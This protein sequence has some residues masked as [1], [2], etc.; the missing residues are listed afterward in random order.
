MSHTK[1]F[2]EGKILS[3]LIRFALPVLFAMFLQTMY[4]AVDMLVVGQ[5]SDA[6]AVSAVS[7]GSWVMHSV[8]MGITALSMGTTVLLGMRIGEGR[9][10][11]AGRVVGGSIAFF[12]SIA[13]AMTVIMFALAPTFANML[14]APAEAFGETVSYIRICALGGI[15]IVAYNLIGSIF[16]G[17][18]NSK[19]PLYSVIIACVLNIIGDL[20]FVGP[21]KMSA[22]GAALATVISQGTSVVISFFLIKKMG[23]PFDFSVK[24]IGFHKDIIKEVTGIGL[25]VAFQDVLV[26]ISFL[27]ITAIVNSLGVVISAGVGIAEKLCGFIM[28]VPSAFGQS[29]S[30]FVAQNIGAKRPDRARK[31]L[32]YAVSV[33]FIVGVLMFYISFFHG[34]ILSG[35]FSGESEVIRYSA[36]YLKSYAID[37]LLTCFL[38]CFTGYFNGCGRTKFVMI[39]GIIGAFA[40]RIP[41][42]YLMSKIMPVSVFRVGLATPCST[43]VQ[44][45]LCITYFIMMNKKEKNA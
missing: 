22:N 43:I 28:L 42:S 21:L 12:A 17:I 39:Q 16:R 5:F 1:T 13:L 45:I 7:T 6:A 34:D 35:I 15:F 24:D 27:A 9:R 37:C 20:I 40:V 14:H 3:P 23:L 33:S 30:A 18:G 32:F 19:L 8:T 44:I 26:S 4:G 10:H 2:T 11:E 25:P 38:F 36:E 31:A 29:M 41:V